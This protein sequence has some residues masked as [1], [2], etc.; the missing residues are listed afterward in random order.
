MV[1]IIFG[2]ECENCHEK[3]NCPN[4]FTTISHNCGAYNSESEDK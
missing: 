4:A 3:D 1:D 2:K